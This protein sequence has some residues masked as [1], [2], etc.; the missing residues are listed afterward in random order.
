MP[1]VNTFEGAVVVLGTRPEIIKL[2]P[3]IGKMRP[4]PRLIH[5]GQHYDAQLSASFFEAFALRPPTTT[6]GVGGK[7]RGAQIGN[8]I[9]ALDELFAEISPTCVIAQGDTNSTVAAAVA[10]NAREIPLIHVEAGLR[11]FDR[12]MPEEHNR[13]IADHLTDL[14]LAP[15]HVSRSNLV[16]EGIDEKRISIT[17]NTVVDAVNHLLPDEGARAG[18]LAQNDVERERFALSTFHR[19]ENVD[20]PDRLATILDQLRLVGLPVVLPVHPRTR[21]QID[22]HG[23]DRSGGLLRLIDPIGYVQFL[24]LLAECALAIGDSGGVQE[25]VSVLKRPMIV[26]RRS[27]E[28]PEVLD[29]FCTLVSPD[30]ISAR[31]RDWL[32]DL[33][34]NLRRLGETPSPYGDGHAS[35]RSVEAIRSHLEAG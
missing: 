33:S 28:R 1:S 17:G 10:A 4:E 22:R 35:E 16:A 12:A 5:T 7:S 3:I 25:E 6:L 9:S 32:T 2:A 11:S 21:A 19:P 8:A 31:A 18:I 29:T 13:V 15:T 14:C 20:D 34:G 24:G 27:T 23:L 30:E 26:V